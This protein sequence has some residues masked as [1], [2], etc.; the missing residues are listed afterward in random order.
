[1]QQLSN[2]GIALRCEGRDQSRVIFVS[3]EFTKYQRQEI[4]FKDLPFELWEA[5][6]YE[7]G[8]MDYLKLES[9]KPA[10]SITKVFLNGFERGVILRE[11]SELI[12]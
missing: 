11:S 9:P 4:S 8:L 3:P 6:K 1:M 5:K 7:N 12:G 2:L 10:E